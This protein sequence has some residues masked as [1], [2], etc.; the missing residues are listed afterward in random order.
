MGEKYCSS[1]F[2]TS[3]RRWWPNTKISEMGFLEEGTSHIVLRGNSG[4]YYLLEKGEELEF[5][6]ESLKIRLFWSSSDGNLKSSNV[7]KAA[8]DI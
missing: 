2:E 7:M 3:L 1:R 6:L 4:K 8:T 5:V